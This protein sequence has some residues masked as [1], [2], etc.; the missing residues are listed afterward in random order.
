MTSPEPDA[1]LEG[2]ERA[3]WLAIALIPGIGWARMQ[4]LIQSFG[5]PSGALAAPLAFLE[6][7][8][9][10]KGIA[11][12]VHRARMDAG[13]RVQDDVVRIG[14]TLLL[15]GD[16]Q[17]PGSLL[18]VHSPPVLLFAIGKLELLERPAVAIVGSRDHTRYGAE[19]CEALAAG[20]AAAGIVVVSGMARGLDAVAHN[21]ALVAGGASI[22]VLGCGL[23]VVYPL[24]L[25]HI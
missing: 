11:A 21:A 13:Y 24:S 4:T 2:E 12:L 8:P 18:T 14:A 23:G 25:I 9:A 7:L 20:A 10:L 5:S 19:V 16:E 15:P 1:P 17:F 3:A 22:G 6:A